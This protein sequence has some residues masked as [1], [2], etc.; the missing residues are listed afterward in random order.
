MCNRPRAFAAR[1]VGPATSG[2]QI[3]VGLRRVAAVG[4]LWQ[5]G[6][7]VIIQDR[8]QAFA[9]RCLFV[10]GRPASPRPGSRSPV[11]DLALLSTTER[12][13]TLLSST[14]TEYY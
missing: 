7:A 11:L 13:C 8:T 14:C 2:R 5:H 10:C 1:K 4:K 12:Y 9:G 3:S 6:H